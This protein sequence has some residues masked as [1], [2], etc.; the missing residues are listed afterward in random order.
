MKA[1]TVDALLDLLTRLVNQ[2]QELWVKAKAAEDL[3][4]H[5]P[6]YTNYVAAQTRA[7]KD[8]LAAQKSTNSLNR[9]AQNFFRIA[10]SRLALS[11]SRVILLLFPIRKSNLGVAHV[12]TIPV[13]RP[14]VNIPDSKS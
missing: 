7:R 6:E 1:D 4:G 9:F 12:Q 5:S 8:I 11:H 10:S 2:S 14:S 13:C 3:F